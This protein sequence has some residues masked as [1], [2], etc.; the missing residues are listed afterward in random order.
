MVCV[1]EK[2]A[3]ESEIFTFGRG[4]WTRISRSSVKKRRFH[5]SMIKQFGSFAALCD[6]Q[7]SADSVEK[8]DLLP[9]L[10][11]L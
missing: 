5:Q 7:K 3:P 8:V 10:L 6:R 11:E 1:S 9:S 4:F 2:Y